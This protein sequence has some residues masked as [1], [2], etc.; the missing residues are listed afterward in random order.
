M[1]FT[2]TVS[3]RT[4]FREQLGRGKQLV[5]LW[6]LAMNQNMHRPAISHRVLTKFLRVSKVISHGKSVHI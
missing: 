6:I 5:V 3:T 1:P 4:I 2:V